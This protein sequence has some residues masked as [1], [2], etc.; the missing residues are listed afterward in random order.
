MRSSSGTSSYINWEKRVFIEQ[1]AYYGMA[2]S[3]L[4]MRDL[5]KNSEKES[6]GIR[7][8][9]NLPDKVK[10]FRTFAVAS[11]IQSIM[12]LTMLAISPGEGIIVT[13]A[14]ESALTLWSALPLLP[15]IIAP[16]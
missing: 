7:K 1:G 2:S 5:C 6:T 10:K 16:A 12:F 11:Q 8:N 9:R 13:P 15:V 14:S 3:C 4:R